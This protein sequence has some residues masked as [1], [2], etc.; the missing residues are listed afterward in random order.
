M[1]QLI[2]AARAGFEV[3][4]NLTFLL[5]GKLTVQILQ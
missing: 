4:M 5:G 2:S 3:R 1:L